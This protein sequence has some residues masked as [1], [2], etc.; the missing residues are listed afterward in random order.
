MRDLSH[1]SITR[2][3]RTAVLAAFAAAALVTLA[4]YHKG[5]FQGSSNIASDG[6]AN[7]RRISDSHNSTLD[8]LLADQAAELVRFSLN[9]QRSTQ[10]P[11]VPLYSQATQ[12]VHVKTASIDGGV[13][14]YDLELVFDGKSVFFAVLESN[15]TNK[16]IDTNELKLK[17]ISCIP[18]PCDLH[19]SDQLAVSSS[20][21]FRG[22]ETYCIHADYKCCFGT[23]CVIFH[24]L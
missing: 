1:H 13:D 23:F 12:V 22:L 4:V 5:Q 18:G 21:L 16:Q 17:L 19:E 7:H 24:F 11:H 3:I 6:L 15:T 14:K 2:A 8:I 20:G 10:C 9:S